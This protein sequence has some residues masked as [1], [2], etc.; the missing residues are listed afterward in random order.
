MDA[1]LDFLQNLIGPNST[2]ILWW[3]MMFRAFTVFFLALI[4]VR[5]GGTRI[6][7]ANT[8]FDIVLGIILGSILSRAITGN[9]PYFP[10]VASAALLVL[11][12]WTLSRLALK[13]HRLGTI[14][15]GQ[16]TL[17]MENGQFINK[18]MT[19]SL[20]TENDFMEALRTKGNIDVSK[21][22]FAYLERSGE[23]SVIL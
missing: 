13:S 14:I 6:F 9:A 21:V 15:K 1:L 10:T 23:I 7:G 4:M 22:K 16:R 18:N 3:Q 5:L 20:I 12:H 8:S 11:L 19:K 17:L 2:D